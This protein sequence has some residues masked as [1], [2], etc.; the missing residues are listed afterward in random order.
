MDNLGAEKIAEF[1]RPG[2]FY[3]FITYRD[4][5][6][7]FVD[8]QG[9]RRNEFPNTRVYYARRKAPLADLV[10][11]NLLEPTQFSEI[12][13]ER[14]LALLRRLKVSRYQV[15][16][17]M[18]SPV[19]HTRPI[20]ITGRSSDPEITERLKKLGV[21]GT[22]GGQYQG[23]TSILSALS[24]KITEEDI[25]TVNLLAHMPSHISLQEPDYNG[26]YGVLNIISRLES[27][28]IRLDRLESRGKRQYRQ[29][30]REVNLSQS[31]S[32][33]SRELEELYDQEEEKIKEDVVQLPPNIQKAIDE[34][35]GKE[36]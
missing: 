17:A 8:G 25:T 12:F 29:V 2:D 1:E 7:T 6:L 24:S 3:N 26:V 35:F 33:L 28:D 32:T 16:G 10:L 31:L 15:I 13:T 36:S 21:R 20:R 34:A 18:G 30:N 19:P 5:S 4:R 23:P 11:M 14:I 22:S 27:I 9:N